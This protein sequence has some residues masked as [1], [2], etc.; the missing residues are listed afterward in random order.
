MYKNQI[1]LNDKDSGQ[2][3]DFLRF[4]YLC[5]S[6][7]DDGFPEVTKKFTRL[8]DKFSAERIEPSLEEFLDKVDWSFHT[9][10]GIGMRPP[11]RIMYC[12]GYDN[13][14]EGRNLFLFEC[15][16]NQNNYDLVSEFFKEA[17]RIDLESVEVSE[18][19]RELLK[20]I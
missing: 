4:L 19:T 12:A 16:L 15:P 3:M 6:F 5:N 14:E 17:Y 11:A 1:E 13:P 7:V 10:L 9:Q 8:K 18:Q 20:Y 2:N